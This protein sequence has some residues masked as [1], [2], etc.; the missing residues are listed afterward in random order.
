MK[1]GIAQI[2]T[3]PGDFETTSGRMVA[4]SERAAQEGVELLVFPLAAL[5][6]VEAAAP[7]DQGDF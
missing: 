7:T 3:R 2:N 1:I 5:A 6:G 4:Q